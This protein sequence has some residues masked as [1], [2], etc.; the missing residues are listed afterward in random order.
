MGK[1]LQHYTLTPTKAHYKCTRCIGMPGGHYVANGVTTNLKNH[2][3]YKHKI[4][5][6]VVAP[7]ENLDNFTANSF[8]NVLVH[9]DLPLT[10]TDCNCFNSF[11]NAVR[12]NPAQTVPKYD[13][14]RSLLTDRYTVCKDNIKNMMTKQM[15]I[16]VM[17]DHWTS[18]QKK[19]FIGVMAT[20]LD[21]N[22]TLSLK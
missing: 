1:Y 19:S 8:I 5:T 16:S 6:D 22:F 3:K 14:L 20:W 21:E 13:S 11:V 12:N 4:S 17:L 15:F 7:A 2:L 9:H 10:L 18:K